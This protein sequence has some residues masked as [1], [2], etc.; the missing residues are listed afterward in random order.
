MS[1]VSS[2]LQAEKNF[3]K[4]ELVANEST[5]IHFIDDNKSKFKFICNGA[6]PHWRPR[7]DLHKHFCQP[8]K[9][10][11][12]NAKCSFQEQICRDGHDSSG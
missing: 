9:I 5:T 10:A 8:K 6:T 2:E 1:L 4:I 7:F 12:N 11:S 3:V